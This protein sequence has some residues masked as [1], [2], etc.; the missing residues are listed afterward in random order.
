MKKKI[1]QSLKGV[2]ERNT[3]RDIFD[4]FLSLGRY[5]SNKR[6]ANIFFINYFS[7]LLKFSRR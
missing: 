1:V 5:S 4:V 7:A 2:V 3:E 6:E